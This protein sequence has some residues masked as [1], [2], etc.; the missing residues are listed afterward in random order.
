MPSWQSQCSHRPPQAPRLAPH[1][2]PVGALVLPDLELPSCAPELTASW[3]SSLLP[4]L[5][6]ADQLYSSLEPPYAPRLPSSPCPVGFELLPELVLPPPAGQDGDFMDTV[7]LNDVLHLQGLQEDT[8]QPLLSNLQSSAYLVVCHCDSNNE[9][10]Y[11]I[12]RIISEMEIGCFCDI[13]K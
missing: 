8:C 4:E 10:R 2:A 13:K 9:R 1:V 7:C 11:F 5:E 3:E 12:C 6:S